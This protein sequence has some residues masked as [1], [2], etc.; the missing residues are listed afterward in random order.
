LAYRIQR[1]IEGEATVFVLSGEVDNEHTERLQE[2][3]DEE[4]QSRILL[5]LENVTFVGRDGVGFLARAEARGVG[6]INCPQY[7]RS[8]IDAEKRVHLFTDE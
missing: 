5:D 4:E 1:S 7:V 2:L 6:V 8:W 3:L